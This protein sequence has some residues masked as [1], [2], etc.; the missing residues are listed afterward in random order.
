MTPEILI[1]VARA[2]DGIG[3]AA[4]VTILVAAAIWGLAWFDAVSRGR[5]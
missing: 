3:Q 2:M 4:V 1:P 5:G